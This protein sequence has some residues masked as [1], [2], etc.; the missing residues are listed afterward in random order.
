M[1]S[2]QKPWAASRS[3]LPQCARARN[4]AA[5]PR[6]SGSS[7]PARSKAR[8]ANASV[9]SRSPS[10]CAWAARYRATA[11]GNRPNSASST[12]TIAA[13]R[14]GRSRQP[15]DAGSSH[16]SAPRSSTSTSANSPLAM[17]APTYPTL[18]TGRTW[19]SWSGSSSNQRRIVAS[20]RACRR[21]GIASSI[22]VRGS[23]V[24]LPGECVANGLRPLTA[25]LVPPARASMEVMDAVWLL[26]HASAPAGRPRTGGG[27]GTTRGAR[28]AGSRRGS[29]D[30]GPRAWP[31]R[32]PL[33]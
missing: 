9:R 13:G 21:P 12:T 17:S 19:N 32:H 29:V 10:I 5:P 22:I 4:P 23:L 25:L 15:S 2:A 33:P 16:R 31:D 27:I 14:A 28:R 26:A 7:S 24:V 3:P 30:R 8:R 11:L 1:A 18:R 6:P 20:W